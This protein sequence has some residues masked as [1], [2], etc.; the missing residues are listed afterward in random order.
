MLRVRDVFRNRY[1]LV[2]AEERRGEDYFAEA[3]MSPGYRVGLF[4]TNALVQVGGAERI[5]YAIGF[6]VVDEQV[7]PHRVKRRQDRRYCQRFRYY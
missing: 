6:E 2:F 5:E 1:G 3:Y 4:V 7:L